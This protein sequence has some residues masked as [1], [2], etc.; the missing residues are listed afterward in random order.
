[1][2]RLFAFALLSAMLS[3]CIVVPVER[4]DRDRYSYGYDHWGHRYEGNRGYWYHDHGG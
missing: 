2:K 3:G 1:M 4:Y